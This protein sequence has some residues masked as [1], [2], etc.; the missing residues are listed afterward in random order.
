MPLLDTTSLAAT[1]D[2]VNEAMFLDQP[3]PKADRAAVARWIAGRQGEQRSYR[4]MPAPTPED[5][6]SRPRL[7]TGERLSSGASTGHVLGEEACRALIQL[8]VRTKSID[9]A[10]DRAQA[11]LRGPQHPR[12]MLEG[13]YRHR[14]QSTRRS[15]GL[16]DLAQAAVP[17]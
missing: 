9:D 3:V 7:F 15:V 16:S 4:G 14:F 17:R 5:F 12:D 10:L 1:L 6:R 8:G 2:A 11:W 13:T